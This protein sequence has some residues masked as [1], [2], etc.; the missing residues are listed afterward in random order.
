MGCEVCVGGLHVS[1]VLVLSVGSNCVLLVDGDG[2]DTV[3]THIASGTGG[4]W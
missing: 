3:G 4:C 1:T 2:G